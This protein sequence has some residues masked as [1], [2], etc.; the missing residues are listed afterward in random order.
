MVGAGSP[1][2]LANLLPRLFQHLLV[3]GVLPLHQFFDE[4]EQP[5]AL[6]FLVG[7]R[8]EQIETLADGSSTICAKITARAV[9]NGFRAHHKCS[10]LG[11]PCRI[12]FSRADAA[13]IAS[14][15]RAT[16]MSFLRELAS[17][18]GSVSV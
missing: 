18:G 17:G 13:L 8:R 3:S 2:A 1:P 12:D 10:V 16:S 4:S 14:S 9:A 11:C 7:L 6:L 15:G 5:L